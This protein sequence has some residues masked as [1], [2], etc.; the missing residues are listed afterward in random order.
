MIF[1]IDQTSLQNTPP[2]TPTLHGT[3]FLPPSLP[4]H[5]NCDYYWSDPH[6]RMYPKKTLSCSGSVHTLYSRGVL[7][8][9]S[10]ML[11]MMVF[12]GLGVSRM[13][14]L[15]DTSL[16][17]V[18]VLVVVVPLVSGDALPMSSVEWWDGGGK[19]V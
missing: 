11:Y 16:L 17:A 6:S 5:Q 12:G 10:V 18:V 2:T 13:G 3:G 8:W 19:V 7:C 1:K 9:G 15:L 4:P 14:S